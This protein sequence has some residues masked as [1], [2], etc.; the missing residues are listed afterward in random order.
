MFI[1]PAFPA[2]KSIFR[3]I[4]AALRN[5]VWIS[6]RTR[7]WGW[8][9]G[10]G[11][12]ASQAIWIWCTAQ[13]NL[14]YVHLRSVPH[15][16]PMCF[17][18]SQSAHVYTHGQAGGSTCVCM[19]AGFG[20]LLIFVLNCFFFFLE[21]VFLLIKR[22]FR[23]QTSRSVY[24]YQKCWLHQRPIY[25]PLKFEHSSSIFKTLTCKNDVLSLTQKYKYCEQ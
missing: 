21:I 25:Y 8:S 24:Q 22:R 12:M 9:G 13:W 16:W 14:K 6:T 3:R 18:G 20:K 1:P 15:T 10:Q 17:Q 23:Y 4:L 7:R 11:A 2:V 5:G 19:C